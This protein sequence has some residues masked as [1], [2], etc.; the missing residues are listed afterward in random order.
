MT[1]EL[2]WLTD[3]D[4]AEVAWAIALEKDQFANSQEFQHGH[5]QNPLRLESKDLQ[6]GKQE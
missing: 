4:P 3:I 1:G 2:A 6:A 5:P